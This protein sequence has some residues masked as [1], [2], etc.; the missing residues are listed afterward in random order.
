MGKKTDNSSVAQR[1]SVGLI[2]Q[3]SE[4]QNLVELTFWLFFC[5]FIIF[6]FLSFKPNKCIFDENNIQYC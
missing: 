6:C 3:R 5:M 1:Q 4:D 2:T